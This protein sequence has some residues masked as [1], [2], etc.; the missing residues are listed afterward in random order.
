MADVATFWQ[1]LAQQAIRVFVGNSLPGCVRISEVALC[2]DRV[3]MIACSANSLRQLTP[4][5]LDQ[6]GV[7]P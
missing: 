2:I 4:S 3:S 6:L 1:L 5:L 7:T